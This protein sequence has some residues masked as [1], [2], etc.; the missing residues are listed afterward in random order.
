M[1]NA[2]RGSLERLD[3]VAAGLDFVAAGLDFVGARLDRVARHVRATRLH[4][5]SWLTTRT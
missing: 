1:V 5:I 4:A 3:F 2:L